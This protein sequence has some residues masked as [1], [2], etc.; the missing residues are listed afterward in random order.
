MA[1]SLDLKVVAEGVE[2]AAQRDLLVAMGCDELQ[3]FFF[4]SPMTAK[5]LAL[6]ADGDDAAAVPAF[7]A[8]LFRETDAAPL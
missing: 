8:S 4:A 7:R 3:G 6:W 2:T 1:H 5:S